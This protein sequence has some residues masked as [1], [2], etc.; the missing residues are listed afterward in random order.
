[1]TNLFIHLKCIWST[2]FNN[3]NILQDVFIM[4][5]RSSVFPVTV[6]T[7]I[8]TTLSS[9]LPF[10]ECTRPDLSMGIRCPTTQLCISQFSRCN[11]I[12]DC[13]NGEDESGCMGMWYDHCTVPQQYCNIKDM[14]SAVPLPKLPSMETWK[15]N[16]WYSSAVNTSST[17]MMK[18]AAKS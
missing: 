17:S 13:G 10:V 16:S 5:G 6:P 18:C 4:K 12:D 15:L 1:M 14:W 9:E 8:A 7:K 3:L 2:V 11:Y